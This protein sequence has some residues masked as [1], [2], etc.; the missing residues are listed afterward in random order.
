MFRKLVS[1]LAFSPAVITDIGF[2]ARRLRK[3][4]VT[5]RMSL[6]FI[7]LAMVMQSLAVFSPPQSANASSEQDIIRG[8]V[9]DLNDFVLRYDHNEDDVK[10]IYTAIGITRD[11]IISAKVATVTTAANT[12]L[13]SRYGQLGN[14]SQE[15]SLSY[16]RSAG[17]VGVRY[18]DPAK[19][20]NLLGK[21]LKGWVGNSSS[22]GW[23]AIIQSNGSIAT[24]GIPASVSSPASSILIRKS[25]SGTNLTQDG[26]P[27]QNNIA[28]PLDKISYSIQVTNSGTAPVTIPF[29]IRLSDVL[30]YA[31]VI[32]SGGG[33][34]ENDSQA[35]GWSQV[36]LEPGQTQERQFAIQ[37]LPSLPSTA[38]GKSN[39]SS[40][41]CVLSLSFGNTLNTNADC[42]AEKNLE[43]ILSSL[44]TTG[45][46]TN[47]GFI[48]VTLAIIVFFYIRTQQLNKELRVIRHTM[49][50]GII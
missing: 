46:G 5:R 4:E 45:I 17:G 25:I 14:S 24:E 6:L 28:K 16:P 26:S 47:I 18:F 15:V 36:Q 21:H 34:F 31:T 2:Y 39:A 9:T 48:V 23:F 19:D 29:T 33:V 11:E 49:N 7:T 40:Y 22:T 50:T 32:D 10:D 12:Y 42:P 8:G 3:E 27:V 44:P 30:E 37:L 20:V 35:L 43:G 13:L 1:N 41:D 38:E